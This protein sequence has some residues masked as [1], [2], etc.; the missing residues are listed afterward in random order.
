MKTVREWMR[1]RNTAGDVG[2][3]VEVEGTNLPHID[4]YWNVTHDGSLRGEAL[5][6]VFKRPLEL[7]KAKEALDY[8]GHHLSKKGVSVLDSGRCGVHVHV[9]CQKLNIVELY[10]FFTLNF[11][12]EDLLTAFCGESRVGN[13]FCLRAKD[14]EYL[15]EQLSTAAETKDFRPIFASDDLRYAAMNVKSLPQYGSLEFRAMR[16]TTD[17]DLIYKWASILVHLREVA[18]TYPHPAE[19]VMEMSAG[20]G[21]AFMRNVLGEYA[22]EFMSFDDWEQSLTDGARIAQD[23]AYAGDWEELSRVPKKKIGGIEVDGNWDEDFPPM[24]V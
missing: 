3:E 6:Y 1:V 9:N 14:A 21:E 10:N 19:I 8:L 4:E 2:I 23:V 16:G 12:L 24:D 5:E 15:I 22:D 13:L 7:S 11:I 17:P 18:K 20:G